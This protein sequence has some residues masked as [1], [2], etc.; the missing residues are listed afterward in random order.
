[1]SLESLVSDI[2]D[3]LYTKILVCTGAGISVAAGL[4][5]FRN[6]INELNLNKFS[7]AY[8]NT[9]D[10]EIY[11]KN[12]IDE[13]KISSN[14]IPTKTHEFCGWLNK[15]GWLKKLY[16]QNIDELHKVHIPPDKLIEFHG[17]I[18][19]PVLYGDP[20]NKEI[21]EQTLEDFNDVD[22]L[23]VMGTSLQVSPFCA[24]PNIVSS[25]CYRVLINTNLQ[26][27][28]KNN[29]SKSRKIYGLSSGSSCIKIGSRRITL[30]PLWCDKKRWKNK[31]L[32]LNIT[33]DEFANHFSN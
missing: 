32:L 31:Q 16:T 14:L 26:D 8:A 15:K 20:I 25:T 2:N 18:D 4:P 10:P 19:N 24:L 27:C 28:F 5:T 9:Q 7:R 17:N 3:G 12:L 1:M 23:I 6:K 30:R 11:K 22:L 13:L 33:S 29:W 21:L